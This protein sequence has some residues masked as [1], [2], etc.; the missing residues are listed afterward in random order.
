MKEIPL[1]WS[2]NSYLAPYGGLCDP[3][4]VTPLRVNGVRRYLFTPAPS[5]PGQFPISS[6]LKELLSR[7]PTDSL[8]P[9]WLSRLSGLWNLAQFGCAFG[10]RFVASWPVGLF[11][12]RSR[13]ADTG[14]VFYHSSSTKIDKKHRSG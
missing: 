7:L 4:R 2:V 1:L 5:A 10:D 11:R 6:E 8:L 14:Y 3:H 13:V 12:R 9:Y